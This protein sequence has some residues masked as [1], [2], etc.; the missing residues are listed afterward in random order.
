MKQSANK[1][2]AALP[3][4]LCDKGSAMMVVSL[5]CWNKVCQ[6]YIPS[7]SDK[8][9]ISDVGYLC[10]KQLSGAVSLKFSMAMCIILFCELIGLLTELIYLNLCRLS[11]AAR[12]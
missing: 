7:C 3:G 12:D 8:R 9:S 6:L 2:V 4:G 11:V 10:S 1:V 5:I